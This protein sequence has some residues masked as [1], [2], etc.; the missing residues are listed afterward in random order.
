[1]L[2][3]AVEEYERVNQ[4]YRPAVIRNSLDRWLADARTTLGAAAADLVDEGRRL[5]L[6]EAL[7]LGFDD[8]ACDPRQAEPVPKLTR[9]ESE[10]ALLV[11]RGLTNREVA[12][13]LYLSVRTVEVHVDRILTKLG[14]RTR[15]RL[16]AWAHAE[17][18]LAPD[19]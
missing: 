5:T 15:T 11:A 16:A 8:R 13:Q 19:T 14:F 9:R 18:L 4:T 1:M 12:A 7:A 3:G 2:A 10:V 17:G 6:D